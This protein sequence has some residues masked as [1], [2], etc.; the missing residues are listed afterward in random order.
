MIRHGEVKM[1]DEVKTD[2]VDDLSKIR[3][4][5]WAA[6]LTCSG[7]CSIVTLSVAVIAQRA[8]DDRVREEFRQTNMTQTQH[9]SMPA[10]KNREDVIQEEMARVR[11]QREQMRGM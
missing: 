4:T 3:G 11:T 9:V 6:S 8:G 5:V 10:Q 7:I 2:K 1:T